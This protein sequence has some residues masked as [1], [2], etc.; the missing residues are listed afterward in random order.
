MS[1]SDDDFFYD[2]ITGLEEANNIARL[3]EHRR[4]MGQAR[5]VFL[6]SDRHHVCFLTTVSTTPSSTQRSARAPY[7]SKVFVLNCE[8]FTTK[9]VVGAAAV[10]RFLMAPFGGWRS[11]WGR[12][13]HTRR[14]RSR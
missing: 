1:S 8:R 12:T 9:L 7:R 10:V 11:T 14:C 2:A 6:Y 3:A 4:Q 5:S 13:F